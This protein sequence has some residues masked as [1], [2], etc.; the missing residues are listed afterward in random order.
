MSKFG[1]SLPPGVTR[2]P[3][4]EDYP[5][6]TCGKSAESACDCPECPVCGEVGNT[7][8]Y[9]KGHLHYTKAQLTGQA[10]LRIIELRERIDD[11]MQYLQWL[12]DQPEDYRQ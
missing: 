2:L 5:C 7:Y 4:E 3:G 8:C 10:Q 12:D 6:A 11:E 9:E 1:W